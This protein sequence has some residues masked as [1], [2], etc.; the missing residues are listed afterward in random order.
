MTKINAML[1]KEEELYSSL[2][3]CRQRVKFL[4]FELSNVL[5]SG[6]LTKVYSKRAHHYQQLFAFYQ[7]DLIPALEETVRLGKK[8]IML[9][10]KNPDKSFKPVNLEVR[11]QFK[12]LRQFFTRFEQVVNEFNSFSKSIK[13]LSI[14]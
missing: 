13:Q 9:M 4:R 2:C 3:R 1:N 14:I 12:L 6:S 10:L 5:N 8:H 7:Q 11:N